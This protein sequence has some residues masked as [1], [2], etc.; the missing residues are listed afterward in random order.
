MEDFFLEDVL[1]TL[2]GSW[3]SNIFVLLDYGTWYPFSSFPFDCS[4][5][6]ENGFHPFFFFPVLHLVLCNYVDRLLGGFS[7]LFSFPWFNFIL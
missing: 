2:L 6:F 7:H 1:W 5:K 4:I 3:A